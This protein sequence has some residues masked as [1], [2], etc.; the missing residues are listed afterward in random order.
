MKQI[1]AALPAQR[2]TFS[3][4]DLEKREITLRVWEWATPGETLTGPV[5]LRKGAFSG[6][7][8]A[9]NVLRMDHLD[10]PIGQ[11]VDFSETD[12]HAEAVYRVSKSGRGDE[13]LTLISEGTYKGAS[14][15]FGADEWEYEK[16]ADGRT[17]EVYDAVDWAE[18]S[19][20]WRPAHPGTAILHVQHKG[21][22]N[23]TEPRKPEPPEPEPE[24]TPIVGTL[25]ASMFA[26]LQAGLETMERRFA[27]QDRQKIDLPAGIKRTMDRKIE[28]GR[29]ASFALRVLDGEV[30][31]QA[32][33]RE[34]ALA[35]VISS[36]N[37]GAVPQA[38]RE[39]LRLGFIDRARPFLESTREVPAGDTG[40]TFVIPRLGTKPTV[41]KQATEKA[42]L[43]STA[44]TMDTVTYSAETY[45]GAADLSLQLIKRS[46]PAFLNLFVELLAEAYAVA[47]EDA[48]VD[49]LLAQAA[50]V[51]GTGAFDPGTTSFGEAFTN[52]M[53]VNRLMLPD[54]M[55]LSTAALAAFINEREPAGGG[56]R[57]MYPGLVQIAGV[58]EGGGN[59]PLPIRM[60]PVHVP[61]L[62]DEAVDV[63]IGPSRG[64]VWAEDGTYTLQADV[65]G[66]F[67][68]DVGL[69]GMIWLMPLYPAAFTTYA[70]P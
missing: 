54:R 41:A 18:T 16:L 27:E 65:P 57:P 31:P 29:W 26:R 63:I 52:A 1:Q 38:F 60:T 55:W 20:T 9:G 6:T 36:N 58:S 53:A 23:V 13:A 17:A 70:L 49:K 46:S 21:D 68:R 32:E 35:D 51:E 25:D 30:I 67:G 43:S 28:L 59:G 4:S 37:A 8:P 10:P 5:I 22:A 56:G 45:G 42:E 48:A 7:D 62:D 34:F 50:V 33:L 66:K 47:T 39:E 15:S 2:A 69:A 3:I 12:T 24:P 11:M 40:L 19:L 64:F 44:P 14:V 61:A